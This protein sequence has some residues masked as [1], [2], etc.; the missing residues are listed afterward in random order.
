MRV[1]MYLL[2]LSDVVCVTTAYHRWVLERR[3]THGRARIVH[4]PLCG[5]D[6]PSLE[7]L[8]DESSIL[9]LNCHA[10]HKNLPL[11]LNAFRLLRRRVPG[12]RLVVAG[13]DHPRYPGY[14]AEIRRK[15]E[16]DPGIDWL[17]PVAA[18]DLRSTFS[19]SAVTIVPYRATTGSSATVHQAICVGRPVVSADLP[20]L[21]G[22][23]EEE[24][25]WLEFFPPDNPEKLA[26]VLEDLLTDPIRRRAIAQHNLRSARQNSLTATTRRY[27][28][29]FEGRHDV[30]HVSTSISR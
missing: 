30:A 14:L 7:P 22:M 9:M 3:Q 19:R 16:S 24:D 11:T 23:A 1:A 6:E 5:Y 17:G 15:H 10:P 21:R 27:V 18:Q 28:G 12:A 20:E 2:L 25:L 26:G 8:Q 13:I 29:I 4:L